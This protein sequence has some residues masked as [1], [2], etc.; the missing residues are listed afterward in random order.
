MQ[1]KAALKR[2]L[3]AKATC[4]CKEFSFD[5]YNVG[6]APSKNCVMSS[7]LEFEDV[8]SLL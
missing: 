1:R 2:F 4:K 3:K 7:E 6:D 8:D 5:F